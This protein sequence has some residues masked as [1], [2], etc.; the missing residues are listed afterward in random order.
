[1]DTTGFDVVGKLRGPPGRRFQLHEDAKAWCDRQRGGPHYDRL[2]EQAVREVRSALT[3]R[4]ELEPLDEV[5][6]R[7]LRHTEEDLEL[8][9]KRETTTQESR[10]RLELALRTARVPRP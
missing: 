10:A 4:A 1:M 7:W 9:E 5:Q 6:R 2:L 3:R 8:L